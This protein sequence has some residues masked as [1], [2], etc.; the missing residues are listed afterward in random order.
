MSIS[1]TKVV[2]N[3]RHCESVD[4]RM[5][6]GNTLGPEGSPEPLAVKPKMTIECKKSVK[7]NRHKVKTEKRVASLKPT[8]F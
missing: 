1:G 8:K 5:V 3:D 7:R 2:P 4:L 6:T